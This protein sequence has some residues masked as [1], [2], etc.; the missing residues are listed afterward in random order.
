[1][2]GRLPSPEV[3]CCFRV[4]GLG[5]L[6]RVVNISVLCIASA[7]IAEPTPIAGKTINEVVSGATVQVDTPLG[8]KLPVTYAANGLISGEAGGLAWFLGSS[9]D[10]GRWWVANDRLCQK[11]FK[12]FDAEVQCLHLRREG[13]VLHWSR[14]DGKTGTATLVAA[15]PSE[16]VPAAAP[17]EPV[18]YALGNPEAKATMAADATVSATPPQVPQITALPAANAQLRVKSE[19]KL[20]APTAHK[21]DLLPIKKAQVAIPVIAG[22]PAKV[23]AA[24]PPQ[25]GAPEPRNTAVRRDRSFRVAGVGARD[26]LMVRQ[27]PSSDA[28]KVGTIPPDGHGVRLLGRCQMEWC[29]VTHHGLSGWVNRAY[30]VQEN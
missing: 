1:M 10:R 20:P 29:Q 8:T 18:P 6:H 12:W 26:T 21:S 3:F 16:P 5:M 19:P 27:G 25:V 22:S 30:L 9:T 2:L 14:D 23:T 24:D 7:A 15:A 17:I 28:P 11:W 13:Q 4:K